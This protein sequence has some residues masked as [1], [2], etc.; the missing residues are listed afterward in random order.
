M[1]LA[2]KFYQ[3][4][5]V[6]K[7]VALKIWCQKL[8]KKIGATII[9]N[10]T[11]DYNVMQSI[12]CYQNLKVF[13]QQFLNRIWR[14][15]FLNKKLGLDFCPQ[16]SGLSFGARIISHKNQY[17][18]QCGMTCSLLPVFVDIGKVLKG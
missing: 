16:N 3:Q 1:L 2:T 15:A 7:T 12:F 9:G 13:E 10:T 4:M 17:N 14:V 18:K 6:Q 8:A 5:S 11:Y